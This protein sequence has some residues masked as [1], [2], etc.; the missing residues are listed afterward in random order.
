MF[1]KCAVLLVKEDVKGGLLGGKYQPKK[2]THVYT[3]PCE[4]QAEKQG[5]G[6]SQ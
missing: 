6:G 5:E 1:L 4:C 2:E 3:V